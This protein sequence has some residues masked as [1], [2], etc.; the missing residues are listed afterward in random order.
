MFYEQYQ[1]RSRRNG[2]CS[3]GGTGRRSSS[4]VLVAVVAVVLVPGPVASA[5]ATSRR[6]AEA[7]KLEAMCVSCTVVASS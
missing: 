4:R 6:V 3:I 1:K 7:R 5:A 2:S